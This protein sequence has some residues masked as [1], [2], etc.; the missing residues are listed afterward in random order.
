MAKQ[1]APPTDRDGTFE[2]R[3]YEVLAPGTPY[4][5]AVYLVE[6]AAVARYAYRRDHHIRGAGPLRVTAL[7][8]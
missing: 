2:A 5:R 7:E 1:A 6:S 4:P 3:R 8:G